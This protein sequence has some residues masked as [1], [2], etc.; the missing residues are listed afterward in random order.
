MKRFKLNKL[1]MVALTAA[2]LSAAT[3][4]YT[5]HLAAA[6]PSP[7]ADTNAPPTKVI[8]PAQV[9]LPPVLAEVL[10]L[11]DA[12][13]SDDVI[14]AYIRNSANHYALDANQIVYL[15][16]EGVSS[17]VLNALVAQSQTAA[18][19]QSTESVNGTTGTQ[20]GPSQAASAATASS[21]PVSGVATNYYDALAPYG[22]WLYLPADG[23]C[24]QPT[25]VVANPAWSP[26]GNEGCWLWTDCGW[27]W[28]SYYSW[29]WAPFHYGRWFRY[30]RYGWV[31]RP[32]RV[33]GPAWVCWRSYPGYCGWAPLPPGACFTAGVGWIFNGMTVGLD[34]GFG[35][36]PDCFTFCDYDHFCSRRPFGHFRHGHDAD[37][38]FHG[39]RVNNDFAADPHHSFINRG[40]GPARIEAATHT[41]IHQVAVRELPRRA[42]RFEDFTMP[43]RLTRN[44]NSA[45]IYR[46]DRNISVPRNPFLPGREPQFAGRLDGLTA[47]RGYT[48]GGVV[49]HAPRPQSVRP[50]GP[51]RPT[52]GAAWNY[53]HGGELIRHWS[54]VGN[55]QAARS[56]PAP[57]YRLGYTG[58]WHS[59]APSYA[60]RGTPAWS[61]PQYH[62]H[63]A[64]SFGETHSGGGGGMG[65]G[66][67]RR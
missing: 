65:S 6:T 39:S 11:S 22:T 59:T 62:S 44:G 14:T 12:G 54:G 67:G 7:S 9:N 25:V 4:S 64:T 15:R 66:G 63:P 35:L 21:T 53:P 30:P 57:A 36:G 1:A 24:W 42:G 55:F 40:I 20:S 13:I 33:W 58:A 19:T 31:W 60:W 18:G 27:Y 34:F 51:P 3:V 61:V 38:F 50:N 2:G 46:P 5:S 10:R 37:R 56:V 43:D 52:L 26:Y 41:P 48:S 49:G 29:G 23:W 47:T 32:D 16:D 28:N 45:V 8:A 17:T